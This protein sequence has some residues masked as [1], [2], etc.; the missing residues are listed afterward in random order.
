ME[1]DKVTD[2][3]WLCSFSIRPF[4]SACPFSITDDADDAE[5]YTFVQ[6]RGRPQLARGFK[7]KPHLVSSLTQNWLD[8]IQSRKTG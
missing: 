1:L 7:S 3:I 5:R 6:T 4:A 8:E 2:S